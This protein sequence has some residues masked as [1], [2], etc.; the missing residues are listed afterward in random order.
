MK[1]NNEDIGLGKAT[2]FGFR[3]ITK[4]GDE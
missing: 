1:E 4:P 2:R 3:S